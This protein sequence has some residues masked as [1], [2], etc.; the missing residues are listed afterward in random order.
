MIDLHNIRFI[1]HKRVILDDVTLSMKPG[2]HWVILGR[3]G[4]GKT[5]I[6]EML[7]GYT[8][9]TSGT[10]TVLGQR[11]GEVD[12]REVRK[13]IGYM[14]QSLFEKF[15]LRDPVWEI[16][17]SGPYG[18]LRIYH[19]LPQETIEQCEQMMEQLGIIHLKDQPL[20]SLSQGERKKVMLARI[21]MQ[22]PKLLILD[23]PC[24][25]LDLY[26][27]EKF[28]EDI[29][30]LENEDLQ[31]VYVTHHSEEIIPIFTHAALLHNGR[32]IAAGEKSDILTP[33]H[34]SKL[35]E[36]PL[37]VD[38]DRGRPWLKV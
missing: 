16:V 8:F 7:N 18:F 27:R 23:E 1:R 28:L 35:Y 12:V 15:V 20:G 14:S 5:T 22:K 29:Q 34:L 26:E 9:P 4:S 31:M 3:N 17:A 10:I 19:K 38:W 37:I 36:L 33:E 21:L 32:L 2:E 30:R 6:L 25:G 24:S 13:Q 11:Y